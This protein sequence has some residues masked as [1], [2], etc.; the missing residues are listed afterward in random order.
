MPATNGQ[1]SEP[2][3][4][5]TESQLG[6]LRRFGC[7]I[8]KGLNKG[9]AHEWLEMLISKLKRQE[10]IT[11]EDVAHMPAPS[12]QPASTLPPAPAP[13]T[14]PAP[15]VTSPPANG[16]ILPTSDSWVHYETVRQESIM[17][18]IVTTRSVKL[19]EHPAPG[20][21]FEQTIARLGKKAEA[22]LPLAP[23]FK[24]GAQ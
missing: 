9:D 22:A 7:A 24:D 13:T 5:P 12:F 15:A 8:P 2:T 3:G 6:A 23:E 1:M 10:T 21:T 11:D 19:T 17:V 18:G 14:A 20:E 16:D 4:P